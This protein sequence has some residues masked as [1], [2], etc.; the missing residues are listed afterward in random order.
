MTIDDIAL[1]LH[2][3]LGLIGIVHL[4]SEMGSAQ[5]VYAASQSELT[6]S[7]VRLNEAI[8][9][10][11]IHKTRHGKAE[12]ELRFLKRNALSAVASTD[13][14]YP[15]LLLECPDYPHVLYV[16][17]SS[18]VLRGK[19]LSVVG[20]RKSTPYGQRMCDM[21]IGRIAEMEPNTVIV[22]GL[23]FGIDAEAHRAALRHGLKTVAV[24]A[25]P[26]PDVSPSQ[27]RQL[28]EEI[29]SAGGAVIT[30]LHSQTKQNGTQYI[31]RNR[32]IA[33][34]S[35]GTIVIESPYEGGAIHTAKMADSY[36]RVVMALPGRVGDRC[37]DGTNNLITTRCA[38][39]VCSGADIIRE[40]GW[41]IIQA[42][43]M[44]DRERFVP[45]LNAD[46]K[47]VMECFGEGET[48]DM[49]TLSTRSGVPPG[50]LAAVLLNL[51]IG[52]I[53]RLLPGRTY[54]STGLWKK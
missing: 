13:E 8:A 16:R 35:L 31:P 18:D 53:V 14:D 44:P 24:I 46:E 25:N 19:M 29:I 41:N 7:A 10:D 3:K 37:S 28:A 33:G 36:N 47:R 39:M 21:L 34:M 50:Q 11:I 54:E 52:G 4:L 51:E 38:T 9:R 30:E 26:L 43:I 40:L 23:A 48:L 49:D 15:S 45:T 32:I 42:G 27:H 5:A 2:E 22:S 6:D 1:T 12:E 17:G 20:T